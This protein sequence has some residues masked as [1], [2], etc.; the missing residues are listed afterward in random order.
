MRRDAYVR[1]ALATVVI[2]LLVS[3]KLQT[4]FG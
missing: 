3:A 4:S 1:L 2:G